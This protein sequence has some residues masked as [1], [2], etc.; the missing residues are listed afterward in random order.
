MK[1]ASSALSSANK[2]NKDKNVIL[3]LVPM[4]QE[5]AKST[6]TV[7]HTLRST[8]ADADS[9]KYKVTIPIL[10]GGEDCRTVIM[11][12]KNVLR[13]I[14]GL[15]VT[16]HDAAI[17]IVETLI[18]GSPLA[19]FQAGVETEKANTLETRVAAAANVAAGAAIRTAGINSA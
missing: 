19:I 12:R 15:N 8:P 18:Q 16:D 7:T 9:P 4:E 10:Q 11:W 5:E 13:V 17:P 2:A 3:P 14:H 1:I 6:Q